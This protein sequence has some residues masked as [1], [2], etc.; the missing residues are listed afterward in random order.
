MSKAAQPSRAL[1][2]KPLYPSLS[3]VHEHMH[4]HTQSHTHNHTHAIFVKGYPSTGNPQ[5]NTETPILSR[6]PIIHPAVCLARLLSVLQAIGKC[7][8]NLWGGSNFQCP[9]MVSLL[10]GEGRWPPLSFTSIRAPRANGIYKRVSV[11]PNSNI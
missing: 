11:A 6:A 4:V 10:A 5:K 7:S 3:M 1:Q 2:E 8:L 9:Q